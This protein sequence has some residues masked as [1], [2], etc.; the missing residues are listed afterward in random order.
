M[1]T[2]TFTGCKAS[3]GSMR[4]AASRRI[5]SPSASWQRCS[6]VLVSSASA[7]ADMASST[8]CTAAAHSG[9]RSTC[10]TT[11]PHSVVTSRSARYSNDSSLSRSGSSARD[12]SYISANSPARS[13]S[14][15]AETAASARILSASSRRYSSSLYVHRHNVSDTDSEISPAAKAAAI[16]RMR[17]QR[18]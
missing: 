7:G 1:C 18:A 5:A 2:K 13:D 17:Q 11:A 9:V 3:S 8:A 6:C 4:A 16:L 10:S 14:N 15:S 12:R